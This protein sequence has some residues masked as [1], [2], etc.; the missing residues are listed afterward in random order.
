L[1]VRDWAR[2]GVKLAR[3]R[4][5]RLMKLNPN[6]VRGYVLLAVDICRLAFWVLMVASL[7]TN[8]QQ[9][10]QLRYAKLQ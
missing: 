9:R 6:L 1:L 8:Y 10:R 4:G 7:I 2:C 3:G 5:D